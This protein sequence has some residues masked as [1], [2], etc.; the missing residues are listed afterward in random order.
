MFPKKTD[1]KNLFIAARLLIFSAI[2]T[3]LLNDSV[4]FPSSVYV[5]QKGTPAYS[6]FLPP[7]KYVRSYFMLLFD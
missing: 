6:N 1:N 5:S 7:R 3:T 2:T 4:N